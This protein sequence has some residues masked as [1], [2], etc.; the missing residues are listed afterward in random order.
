VNESKFGITIFI[1]LPAKSLDK[2][3]ALNLQVFAALK[4]Q[5]KS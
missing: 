3:T 2:S 5:G 1:E 4:A